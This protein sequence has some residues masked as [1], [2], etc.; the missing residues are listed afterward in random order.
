K[1]I[2]QL[3][4]RSRLNGLAIH[5]DVLA[6]LDITTERRVLPAN[7]LQ[8]DRLHSGM[9]FDGEQGIRSL[10]RSVLPR[11]AGKNQPSMSLMDQPDKLQHLPPANLSSFVH[12]N[13]CA[14]RKFTLDEKI[15]DCRWRRKTSLLHLD[16]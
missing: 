10:N 3:A 16:D 5:P 11:V 7:L 1:R 2:I 6:F 8:F 13:D 15:G 4:G 9:A 14:V 12:H